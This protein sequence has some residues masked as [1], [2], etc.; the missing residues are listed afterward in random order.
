M[1]SHRAAFLLCVL[2]AG[3][4]ACS[5]RPAGQRV[6]G[7]PSILLVT[8]DTV[9]ADHVGCYG[10]AEAETPNLD[11]LAARGVLFDDARSHVPL[12]A[13]SHA[14]ILTGVL[15]PRH[16]VRGNGTSHLAAEAPAVAVALHDGGYHTA[17]VVASVVL[18]RAT[19]LNRGFDSYDDNQRVG[20]RSA[21]QYLER[22]A[23]QVESA[24]LGAV[25]RLERPFFLWV[26]FYDPHQPWV[27]PSPFAERHVGRGYDAEIAF[28]DAAF[29]GVLRAATRR[30]G[31]DLVVVVAS[32]HGESLG[33]HGE[34]QHGYT[35]HRGVLRVP[36]IVAGP[37]IPHGR[38]VST[39]V[40][41][42]DLAPTLADL[43]HV[44]L[45]GASGLSLSRFWRDGATPVAD[46]DA[47]LWEET[48]HPLF[49]SGWAPLRG[50]LVRGWHF[51][52]APRPELYD[53]VADPNDRVDVATQNEAKVEELR[54]RLRALG[55]SIGD[56]PEPGVESA[57]TPEE[58][59]RRERLAS[60]GYVSAPV[61]PKPVG[62]RLD[63]KDGLPGFLAVEA[64]ERLIARGDAA[65]ARE[66]VE[67]HLRRDPANPRLWHTLGKARMRLSELA[68]AEDAVRRSL[69]L[70]PGLEFVRYTL[71]EILMRRGNETGARAELEGIVRDNPRSVD[72]SLQLAAMAA[73]RND[74]EASEVIL[75]AAFKA[76]A[77]DPD[78][79]DRLGQSMVLKGR[80]VE[81]Q[82]YFAESLAL[83]P[84]DPN[85]LYELGQ[86]A[87]RAG[88]PA[89]AIE[90]LRRCAEG[91]KAFDCGI[92]LARAYV[93]GPRDLAAARRELL[94]ARKHV[95]EPRLLA[96]VDR[97]LRALNDMAD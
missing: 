23:S 84:D 80:E 81:A 47:A 22:G 44:E 16:G 1:I 76:G 93:V 6:E 83:W 15:P 77:R 48:L 58:K 60:L 37:G 19:G 18:D 40:G 89:R 73:R 25:D 43:A 66:L 91:P 87:L 30:A 5:G 20:P 96:E 34:N 55:D 82:A 9:R 45:R 72:A 27:A 26:H 3:T 94:A 62:G 10:S 7:R 74:H 50:I 59:E 36:L 97:R 29:G 69:A 38:V 63:P 24:A 41:L 57:A 70:A 65:Q 95:A 64:A 14:T 79:L 71:A 33:E 12:T 2:A 68:G 39:T 31:D 32:D 8:I 52:D 92:E 49:D 42:V 54:S 61:P 75:L 28:S 51:V 4:P 90:W 53:R 11:R 21:F 78:L 86:A 35:L 85:A 13:P 46:A 67:P 88:E 56:V 17:A